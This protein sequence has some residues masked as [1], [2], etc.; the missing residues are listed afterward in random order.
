MKFKS[1][2]FVTIKERDPATCDRWPQYLESMK[3]YAGTTVEVIDC[4]IHS[5]DFVYTLRE[6]PFNWHED[7]L[8]MK[9]DILEKELFEI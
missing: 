1:G 4:A 5:R 7:W 8:Y 3:K 6:V 9:N 2:D